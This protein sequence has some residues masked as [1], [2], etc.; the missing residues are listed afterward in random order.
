MPHHTV[1]LAAPRGFCAGV[2]HAV[3]MAESILRL[4]PHPVYGLK[5]IVHN[6]Q[7][8]D[9]L[10]RKGIVFVQDVQA[11]PEGATILFSAH[12]VSPAVR[13]AAA[14]RR[15]EVIDATCPFVMKVHH[16][17]KR[18]AQEGCDIVLIGHRRHDEVIG[19]AG[20]APERITVIEN[21]AEAAA[22]S[23]SDPNRIAV[24]TQTTLSQE[25]TDRVLAVLQRRFPHLRTPARKDICYA[26]TNRQEAV[27]QLARR[28]NL[29]LV[30]GSE[31]S[32][33][34]LRLAEV[35]AGNG[36]K[37]ILLSD[38]DAVT[39]IPLENRDVI[40]LT[41]GASTPES[42]IRECLALLEQRGFDRVEE[43][44]AVDE[45][46]HFVLP[47]FLRADTSADTSS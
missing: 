14:T 1:I 22:F 32:S 44:Q 10:Q 17:V 9:A 2:R 18:F 6:R 34:T 38:P 30:L 43:L 27:K 31:N 13:E 4:R 3:D 29:I 35:A 37:A 7:V 45:D 46:I 20:E 26:T 8:V 33:N 42:F 28:V 41:A 40:G 36:A 19:V 21:E 15:L 16:E 39:L 12:G 25:E 5:E 47:S 23:P 11:V 24:V